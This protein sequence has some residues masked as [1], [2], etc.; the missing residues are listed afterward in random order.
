[1]MNVTFATVVFVTI[2]NA[3][4]ASGLPARPPVF[5]YD[6]DNLATMTA[7]RFADRLELS[8]AGEAPMTLPHIGE[9]PATFADAAVTV[10][11]TAD[12]LRL[13]GTMG[14]TVCRRNSEEAPWQDARLRGIEF[15]ATGSQP[16]WVLEYDEGIALTFVASG[17]PRLT[18][19]LLSVAANSGDRMTIEG[20]DG[21]REVLVVIERAVCTGPSGITTAR[22]VVTTETHTFSGCGRVLPSGRFRGTMRGGDR[23]PKQAVLSIRILRIVRDAAGD[24]CLVLAGWNGPITPNADSPFELDYNPLLVFG[25]DRFTLEASI[26]AGSQTWSSRGRPLVITWG[27][28]ANV[29][30]SPEAFTGRTGCTAVCAK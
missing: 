3:V 28:F 13:T 27:A 9:D 24:G 20:G 23:L 29:M 4:A 17:F 6:C 16:D 5:V 19:T 1:M 2:A 21:H 26:H 22:V 18:A 30:L 15:R 25:D 10:T 7:R 11:M 12:Y 8:G 14:G